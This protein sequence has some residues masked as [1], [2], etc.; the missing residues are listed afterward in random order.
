MLEPLT[1]NLVLL[2]RELVHEGKRRN[3]EQMFVIE[4]PHLIQ[5]ALANK[6]TINL[7]A[8]TERA[9]EANVELI[10]SISA[11][12]RFFISAKD[13]ERVS[14]TESPQGIFALVKMPESKAIS[15]DLVIALDGVQ[16]PGNVGTVIR[17]ACWFGVRDVLLGKG[18]ADLYNP[19]VM[20]ATQG[21]MFYAN[22]HR[23]IDLTEQLKRLKAGGYRI[24]STTLASNAVNVFDFSEDDKSV[25]V[26]G[27]EARGV[28]EHILKISDSLL[29]IPKR[30]G[31]E[32]LN[33][34]V[35]A[36]IFM[37]ELTKRGRLIQGLGTP[38]RYCS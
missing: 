16:D 26:L 24:H 33:V 11:N 35:S 5:E 15:G 25:L 27:S 28:R 18:C 31:G 6:A 29:Y 38:M 30:G 8:A 34:A 9:E 19:K 2:L 21:A 14:D 4:G 12:K 7:I 20:R 32:S 23:N 13:A 36:G 1:K 3:E 17:T 37:A 10:S 22:V